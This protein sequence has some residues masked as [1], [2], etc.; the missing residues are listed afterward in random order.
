MV[1]TV[2]G[3]AFDSIIPHPKIESR[4]SNWSVSLRSSH[5]IPTYKTIAAAMLALVCASTPL[6]AQSPV[7]A[8]FPSQHAAQM[9]LQTPP[10]LWV[11]SFGQDGI[12]A[13]STDAT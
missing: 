8:P 11:H 12:G 7:D 1:H 2:V 5:P 6:F 13:R 9:S 10:A 3:Y 4:I